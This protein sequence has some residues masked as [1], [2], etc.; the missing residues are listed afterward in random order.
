LTLSHSLDPLADHSHLPLESYPDFLRLQLEL[1]NE[2]AFQAIGVFCQSRGDLRPELL[3]QVLLR[4]ELLLLRRSD[5]LLQ[6]L[7]NF[8]LLLLRRS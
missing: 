3:R 4:H 2:P 8:S 6:V 5:L 7:L 1:T